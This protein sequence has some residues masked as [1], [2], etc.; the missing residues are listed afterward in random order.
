MKNKRRQT[1]WLL[2]LGGAGICGFRLAQLIQARK[3]EKHLDRK[4]LQYEVAVLE[5]EG[6][7]VLT[8]SLS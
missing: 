2:M 7:I 4:H 5:G 6:G 8:E 3:R 1:G